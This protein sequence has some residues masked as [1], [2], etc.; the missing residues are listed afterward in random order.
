VELPLLTASR[1]VPSAGDKALARVRRQVTA[2][3]YRPQ[4]RSSRVPGRPDIVLEGRRKLI[5]VNS[6]SSHGHIH[7]ECDLS[8]LPEVGAEAWLASLAD[9]RERDRLAHAALRARGWGVLVLW[10]CQLARRAS[11]RLR[12]QRFLERVEPPPWAKSRVRI[13]ASSS[14]LRGGARDLESS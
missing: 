9:H 5:F 13:N 2:L 8:T 10:E 4:R 3:G 11:L 7:P 1:I 14:D 12:V 6:C